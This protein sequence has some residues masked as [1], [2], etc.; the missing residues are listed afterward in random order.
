MPVETAPNISACERSKPGRAQFESRSVSAHSP[1]LE[2]RPTS[3]AWSA[4]SCRSLTVTKTDECR[5][6]KPAPRG[7]SCRW[8]RWSRHVYIK[9]ENK[10]KPVSVLHPHF[11]HLLFFCRNGAAFGLRLCFVFSGAAGPAAP[12][13]WTY[14]SSSWLLW[15]SVH[16]RAGPLWTP[17]RLVSTLALG[18]MGTQWVAAHHGPVVHT[19]VAPQSQDLHGPAGAGGGHL[20]WHLRQLSDL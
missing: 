3:P 17:L 11:S 10:R 18:V 5:C 19:L 12:G 4:T 13:P 15:G 7:P 20:S 16:G 2:S 1:S 8:T 6:L 14:S 9:N